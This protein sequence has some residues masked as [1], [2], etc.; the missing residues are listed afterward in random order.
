[1]GKN[2][3]YRFATKEDKKFNDFLDK[4][5]IGTSY[6]FFNEWKKY[7][8]HTEEYREDIAQ[9][10]SWEEGLIKDVKD[11]DLS[12]ALESLTDNE[13]LVISFCFDKDLKGK[14]IAEKANI[15]LNSVYRIKR[16]AFEG[17]INLWQE[18]IKVLFCHKK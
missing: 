8:E 18:C 10:S 14:E 17:L 4:T 2:Y 6:N 12:I 15:E 3:K 5:I 1:M 16:R 11:S 9:D 7:R 13:R